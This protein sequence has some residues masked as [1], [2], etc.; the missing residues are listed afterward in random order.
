MNIKWITPVVTA[1]DENGRPDP[2]ANSSVY[3]NLILHGMD[4]LL[5]LGSIG[6]FYAMSLAEKKEIIRNAVQTVKHRV[7]LLVGTNSMVP[8]ECLQL[9]AYALEQGADGITVIPPYYFSL[10]DEAVIK[11]YSALAEQ[12]D[13]PLYLYNFPDRTGYDVT[14]QVVYELA[15]EYPNI[16]GIKDTVPVMEHTR[17]LIQMVKKQRPDFEVYSGFDEFFAHNALSGG[18]GGIS[19]ISNF[20]PSLCAGFA[21]AVRRQDILQIQNYQDKIDL[22]MEIY[23]IGKHFVPII[24]QA[25]VITGLPVT[26]QCKFPMPRVTEEETE[27]IRTLLKK[28]GCL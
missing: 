2:D 6:E 4:G 22:L 12:I 26:D 5:I 11:F 15:M 27:K 16:K 7:P 20:A 25:M 21:D 1:L 9:S 19:G 28:A 3:E 24:K 8:E 23:S 14:P 17:K 13:G 18:N 10:S